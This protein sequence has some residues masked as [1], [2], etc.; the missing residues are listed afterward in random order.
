MKKIKK[1]LTKEIKFE[2]YLLLAMSLV[3]LVLSILLFVGVLK[4]RTDADSP[5]NGNEEIF[6][7][8]LFVLSLVFMIYSIYKIMKDIKSKKSVLYAFPKEYSDELIERKLEIIGAEIISVD[9]TLKNIFCIEATFEKAI[10][11][12]DIEES[13]TLFYVECNDWYFDSLEEEQKE[14]IDNISEKYNSL[15]ISS[16]EVINKFI[17]FVIKYKDLI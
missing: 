2:N 4:F 17:N 6:N 5:I 13:E 7:I 10:F 8:I 1:L 11:C 16:L 3:C 9:R 12:C 15:E 14:M